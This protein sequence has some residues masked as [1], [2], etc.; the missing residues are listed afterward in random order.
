M[1]VYIEILNLIISKCQTQHVCILC[2]VKRH[3]AWQE[4]LTD[5]VRSVRLSRNGGCC[6]MIRSQW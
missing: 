6:G 1:M 4:P 2:Y 3:F 5:Y